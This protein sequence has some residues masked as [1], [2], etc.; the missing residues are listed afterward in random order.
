MKYQY[1]TFLFL[2]LIGCSSTPNCPDKI[3]ALPMFGRQKK[4]PDQ[5]AADS[6]F[7]REMDSLF[8]KDRQLAAKDLISGGWEH[9]YNNK[10][11]TAMKRFNQA[12]LLDSTNADIYWGFGNILGTKH[13][14]KESIVFLERSIKMNP[15][16]S[17]V[18]ESVSTS[19]GQL[20]FETKDMKYL[21]LTIDNLKQSIRL[22][23]ANASAFGQLTA[24]YSYFNQKDSAKKYLEITDRLD[25]KAVNPE[26]RKMLKGN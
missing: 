26:V 23:S 1:L 2:I 4:S 24:A 11:D 16:N 3:N 15:K 13:Q 6:I 22:D 7:I 8:H 14:F 25:P 9:F 5:L 20:F 10:L 19:Y 12:W 17:K 21:N 18:Y